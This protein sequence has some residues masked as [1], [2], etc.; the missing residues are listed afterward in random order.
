MPWDISVGVCIVEFV[1]ETL[2]PKTLQGK[3]L[4]FE[5]HFNLEDSVTRKIMGSSSVAEDGCCNSIVDVY[6][7]KLTAFF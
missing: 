1:V 7:P 6:I 3:G 2:R 4:H 5:M